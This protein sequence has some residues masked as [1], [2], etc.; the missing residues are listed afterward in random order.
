VRHSLHP[1]TLAVVAGLSLLSLLSG[2]PLVEVEV[3][4]EEVCLA[5][6]DVQVDGFVGDGLATVHERFV[7]DDLEELHRITDL[8]ADVAFV[9]AQLLARSGIASFDFVASAKVTISVDGDATLPPLTLYQCDGDCA[10][11]GGTLDMI[12]SVQHDAL[13]YLRADAVVIDVELVGAPPR[14]AWSLDAAVCFE[15]RATYTR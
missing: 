7:V 1:P 14:A 8:D 5:Y 12:P 13:A 6:A 10:P 11:E 9:R 3:A 2:C 15:T 4:A